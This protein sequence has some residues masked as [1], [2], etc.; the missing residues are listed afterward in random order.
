[1]KK[2]FKRIIASCLLGVMC[3]GSTF[4]VHASEKSIL[5]GGEIVEITQNLDEN[6]SIMPRKLYETG[7][8][9]LGSNQNYFDINFNT[10]NGSNDPH[11]RFDMQIREVTGGSWYATIVSNAGYSYTTSIYSGGADISIANLRSDVTYTVTMYWVEG[12]SAV[13]GKYTMWTSY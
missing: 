7:D 11:N 13:H 10:K 8:I 12:T 1:M 6:F 4:A 2:R 9:D 5:T 3:L